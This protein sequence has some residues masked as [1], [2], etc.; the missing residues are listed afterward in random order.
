[1]SPV[2]GKRFSFSNLAFWFWGPFNYLPGVRK[3]LFLRGKAA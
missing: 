3:E 2:R 1:L